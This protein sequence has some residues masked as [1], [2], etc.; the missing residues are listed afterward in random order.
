[1]FPRSPAFAERGRRS[2]AARGGARV[3][4]RRRVHALF[5]LPDRK[6]EPLSNPVQREKTC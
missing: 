4:R 6:I 2:A 5:R 3:R 1:V